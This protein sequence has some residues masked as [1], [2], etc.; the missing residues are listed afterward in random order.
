MFADPCAKVPAA[1]DDEN[2]GRQLA[3]T[4][5]L[6]QVLMAIGTLSK[7]YVYFR[8]TAGASDAV[9]CVAA[10]DSALISICIPPLPCP[11]PNHLQKCETH[12]PKCKPVSIKVW[13]GEG[14]PSMAC[15]IVAMVAA[16]AAFP[17]SQ[18]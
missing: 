12:K 10:Q 1:G 3:P 11:D 9:R 5:K 6:E 8:G 15:T 7:Q 13:V 16:C 18:A 17:L 2:A 14:L 4:I